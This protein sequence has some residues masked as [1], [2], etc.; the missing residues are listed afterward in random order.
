MSDN[1][2]T[3]GDSNQSTGKS[4]GR[5][6]GSLLVPGVIRRRLIAKTLIA[7]VAILLLTA[8]IST[9][10]Y[11]GI[12]D[13]LDGQVD[14]QVE[15]TTQ[16]HTNVVE[17]WMTERKHTLEEIERSQEL[18]SAD[19]EAV[20]TFLEGESYE[21]RF[22]DIH[23]VDE[24]TGEVV[25]SSSESAV[26]ENVFDLLDE[27]VVQQQSFVTT[28][29]Y[30]NFDDEEVIAMGQRRSLLTGHVVIGELPA[31]E[32]GPDLPQAIEGAD[33][34]VVNEDGGVIIGTDGVDP[35][36]IE[37]G[38]GRVGQTEDS[39]AIYTYS[40]ISGEDLYVVTT[41]PQETA[42]AVRD[43]VQ[44]S[45]VVTIVLTGLVFV[46]VGLIG[47]RS[48]SKQLNRLQT[49]AQ[50]MEEGNLSVDLQTGRVD[51][52][53]SLYRSFDAMR[54]SLRD[55]IHNA[56]TARQEAETERA[57]VQR[58]NDELEDAAQEYCTVMAAAADGDLAVRA[59]VDTDNETMQTVGEDFN[60]MLDDIEA[61]IA[62]LQTFATE[63][64]IASEQVTASSEEVRSASE[65]ISESVQEISSGSERQN[66]SLQQA[67]GEMSNLSTT[68][69]EIAASSNEVAD[70][71]ART[72]NTGQ[73]G[74]EAAQDAI[75]SMTDTETEAERAVEEIRALEAEVS[76][77]DDL[78]ERIQQIA[79]QTN[80]LALNANIEASRSAS[81][82]DG[83]GFGVV[84]QEIKELSGDAKS[85]AAEIEARLESIREQTVTSAEEVEETSARL[86]SA[87]D[88]VEQAVDALEEIAEYAAETNTGVQEISAATEEQAATTQEVVAIV[89]EAATISEETTAEAE[90]VAA[91]AEEQTT[92]MTEVSGSASQLSQQATQLS[93][94]LD[95]FETDIDD[96]A[97][98]VV[99]LEV[100]ED[101]STGADRADEEGDDGSDTSSGQPDA[102][103]SETDESVVEEPSVVASDD[104][105]AAL[106]AEDQL[107]DGDESTQPEDEVS[108]SDASDDGADDAADSD[109]TGDDASDVFQ[110]EESDSNEN[111]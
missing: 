14:N 71:A 55:Q 22:S 45:F 56:Q 32:T 92:A 36:V 103:A 16:L 41:T 74:R 81:G 2:Q 26:G 108:E 6:I 105:T 99:T 86:E 1:S 12:S 61:T 53:G 85:A 97:T 63:V 73:T 111:R 79:E 3:T 47:G 78:I 44:T 83:E 18:D 88:Q 87:S 29:R 109:D 17:Q 37:P 67:T 15:Q 20:S 46:A 65:Q 58:I 64:A 94:A 7:I 96:D 21:S 66:Q 60:E 104:A 49:R 30:T 98:G 52:I 69:E 13:E 39:Q 33:T 101:G 9:F 75:E 57:R 31:E 110:F 77:I 51:E 102:A 89:D 107:V 34:A 54:D 19:S 76:Q 42:F 48:V 50:T 8:A 91:A 100:D 35:S 95:H 70:L 4:S 28:E 43:E 40:P 25:G 59:D 106:D 62:D 93:E 84:A 11:L 68:T 23:M 80:M 82:D 24:E 90:S 5:S 72:A 10:F 38:A 27:D